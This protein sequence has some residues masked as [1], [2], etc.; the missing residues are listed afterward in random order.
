MKIDIQFLTNKVGRR[1]F[2]LFIICALVPIGILTALSYF[3]VSGQI[4]RQSMDR[5]H[6]SAKSH[7][8]SI[9]ERLLFVENSMKIISRLLQA[10]QEK[11]PSDIQK[12]VEG[13][14]GRRITGLGI[15]DSQNRLKP[16]NGKLAKP[17]QSLL[18]EFD[19]SPEA[20]TRVRFQRKNALSHDIFMAIPVKTNDPS[21]GILVAQ[22][23]LSYLWGVGHENILPPMTDLCIVDQ[24][25]NILIASFNVPDNFLHHIVIQKDKGQTSYFQYQQDDVDYFVSYWSLFI[26]SGFDA[27]NINIILRRSSD[28]IF[29]PLKNFKTLFP[30]VMLLSFWIVTLLS[31]YHIRKSMVPLEKLKRGTV[32]LANNDF[33]KPVEFTSN[34]EFEELAESFNKMARNL[35]RHFDALETR[36]EIDRAILSSLNIREIITSALKRVYTF[37]SC[38]TI[39]ISITADRDPLS[40]HSYS[41]RNITVRKIEEEF[42]R[43][44]EQD[45]HKL[46]TH[47]GKILKFSDSRSFPPYLP[48]ELVRGTHYIIVLPLMDKNTLKGMI[49]MGFK[50]EKAF[51]TEDFDQ[52]RQVADQ[53]TVALS[54]ASLVEALEKLNVGT[55]EALARTVDAKSAWTAGH[56][57]RVADLSVRIGEVMGLETHE[58]EALRRGAYLHDIG[59]I[60]IPLSIL[61]KPGRLNDEEFEMVKNHPDIGSRILEP[62]DAYEDVIPMISQHHERFD[63]TGYPRGLSGEDISLGAR[64]MAVADVYDAVVSD[65]PYRQGWVEDKAIDMIKKSSGI[66]FDPQVVDALLVAISMQH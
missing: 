32:R 19:F 5:L 1:I 8:M 39:S 61:D 20:K 40:H 10:H 37:F 36:S 26:K 17:P 49:G 12:M 25:R 2:L 4:S 7:G 29:S 35:D 43:L 62:I 41:S 65:R 47:A 59:K 57:E 6:A 44:S 24:V 56:S 46:I 48:E 52:M 9:Y 42:I 15:A 18:E 54:N 66:H 16:L 3:Q 51:S 14:S 64:I 50:E 23:D 27:P 63:G 21:A 13:Y 22:I 28:D 30:L 31:V 60:G 58:I 38:D 45:A 33:T 11:K 55:L 53:V 34:D